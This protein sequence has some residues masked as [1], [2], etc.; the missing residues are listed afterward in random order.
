MAETEE[1]SNKKRKKTI[2]V[3][4]PK[5]F[6]KMKCKHT[7]EISDLET[8]AAGQQN[9]QTCEELPNEKEQ[10]NNDYLQ[11]LTVPLT[12][13][14]AADD[15]FQ[16]KMDRW[17]PPRDIEAD[18]REVQFNCNYMKILETAL[19]KTY[20]GLTQVRFKTRLNCAYGC[21]ESAAAVLL[22]FN[23]KEVNVVGVPVV[24]IEK[25]RGHEDYKFP[26]ENAFFVLSGRQLL[27]ALLKKQ[28]GDS[29]QNVKDFTNGIVRVTF[30]SADSASQ[31]IESGAVSIYSIPLFPEKF[32][33]FAQSWIEKDR[34]RDYNWKL[35]HQ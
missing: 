9:A 13:A 16:K 19:Q 34:R 23:R 14:Y 28:F 8:P 29:V 7:G 20:H 6:R 32:I 30:S 33:P 4:K 21:F 5:K 18:Q 26:N 10:Q 22:A 12:M 24:C 17:R 25:R 1:N 3:E 15:T 27:L 31:V 2:S 11:Q 35:K